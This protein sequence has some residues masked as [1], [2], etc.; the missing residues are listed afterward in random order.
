MS[1]C[2]S[3]WKSAVPMV[4][5][6]LLEAWLGKTEKTKYASTLEVLI[7]GAWDLMKYFI[8]KKGETK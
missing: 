4:L 8:S 2:V 1:N 7:V 5:M 3:D 6:L